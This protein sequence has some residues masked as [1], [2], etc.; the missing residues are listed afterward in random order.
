MYQY[1]LCILLVGSVQWSSVEGFSGGPPAAACPT[2]SPDPA[3]HGA[4]P[5]TSPVPYEVNLD[6]LLDDTGGLSYVPGETFTCM[7]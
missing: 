7:L 4:D 2:L 6:S 1:I 5:Q 3:F